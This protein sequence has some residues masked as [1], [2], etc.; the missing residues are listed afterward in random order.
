MMEQLKIFIEKESVRSA[1]ISGIGG[2][3]WVEL[4]F[5]NL[6]EQSYSWERFDSAVEITSL[7][8]NIA[9][10]DSDELYIHLHG[11]FA[12]A[13]FH[14]IGG[15]VTDLEVAGTVELLIQVF[16]DELP[17]KLD[18]SIGLKLFNFSDRPNG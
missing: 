6:A 2:A 8:G 16:D 10:E 4:G 11:T 7:T 12:D 14:A 3:A 13:S 1:W 5:Y 9:Y 18:P 17:R 15:H